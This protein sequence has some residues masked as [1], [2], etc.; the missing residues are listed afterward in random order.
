[1]YTT[2]LISV[3]IIMMVLATVNCE[4]PNYI[5]IC[6]R[7]DPELSACIANSVNTLIPYLKVGIPELDVPPLEPL[8]LNDVQLKLGSDDAKIATNITN[9]HVWGASSFQLLSLR[10]IVSPNANTFHFNVNVPRLQLLG[11]YAIDTK[12]LFLNLKGN[13]PLEINI[14]DYSFNCT[15][16]G[17]KIEK[18]DVTYLEF[19]RMECSM[20]FKNVNVLLKHIFNGNALLGNTTNTVINQNVDMFYKEIKPSLVEALGKTF[21]DIA[22]KI[23][24]RFSYDELFP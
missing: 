20:N 5:H 4:I 9:I 12:I 23:T 8:Q 2:V 15:M 18:N 24:L 16:N 21:T 1:M 17:H 11:Q 7:E 13:G 6:K 19:E 14:T 10:A 3:E 22:N